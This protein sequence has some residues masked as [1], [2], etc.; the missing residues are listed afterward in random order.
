MK[1]G[2]PHATPI[3][4]ELILMESQKSEYFLNLLCDTQFLYY[5]FFHYW[6]VS[7]Y[8]LN[9]DCINTSLNGI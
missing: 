4:V 1:F 3:K 9:Y 2:S 7:V 8:Y 6:I 5:L